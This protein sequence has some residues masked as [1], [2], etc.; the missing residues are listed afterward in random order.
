[1]LHALVDV[2]DAASF[3]C[4]GFPVSGPQRAALAHERVTLIEGQSHEIVPALLE[5]PQFMH[6]PTA[7]LFTGF[8]PQHTIRLTEVASRFRCVEFSALTGLVDVS[9]DPRFLVLRSSRLA[10]PAVSGA[11]LSFLFPVR[12]TEFVPGKRSQ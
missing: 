5:L 1:M 7:L 3:D 11:D 6:L 12:H 2:L 9:D 8:R 4:V 10:L